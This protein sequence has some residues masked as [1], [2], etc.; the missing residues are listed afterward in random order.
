LRS[1]GKSAVAL[2]FQI[3][4]RN[5]ESGS[6]RHL[7]ANRRH[8]PARLCRLRAGARIDEERTL[9]PTEVASQRSDRSRRRRKFSVSDVVGRSGLAGVDEDRTLSRLRGL[10]SDLIDPVIAVHHGCIVKPTGD[11]AIIEFR[12]VV[13]AVRCAIEVQNGLIERNFGLP[14]ERRIEYRAGIHVGDVVEESD[15]DLMGDGVNI[16]AR[17]ESIAKP[18]AICLSERAFRSLKTVDI[19][20]RPIHHRRGDRVRAHLFLCMLAYYLEWHMRQALKPILFDDHDKAEADAARTSIVAKAK[21]STAADRKALTQ[22]TEDGGLPVHSFRSL[23]ADLATV[24]RNTMAMIASPD[25]R[26]VIYPQFTPV[27]ARAFQLLGVNVKL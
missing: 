13:D 7:D 20:V 24:T 11:G 8:A 12:S 4:G 23:L 17:L 26:F 21:R 27:Q 19:E 5:D 2:T 1:A 16:A 22:R 15:G 10:R 6:A 9:A 14:P 18:G 3:G 25:A